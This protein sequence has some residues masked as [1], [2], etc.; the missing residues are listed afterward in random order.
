MHRQVWKSY[1]TPL[2]IH[3]LDPLEDGVQKALP[4][5]ITVNPS[6]ERL[7]DFLFTA[8][9]IWKARN[10]NRFQRKNWTYLQVLKVAEAHRLNH[11]KAQQDAATPPPQ[12]QLDPVATNSSVKCYVD[13]ATT[14]DHNQHTLQPKR[15]GLGILIVNLQGQQVNTI[16]IRAIQEGIYSVISAE[17]AALALAA[18]VLKELNLGEIAYFSDCSQLVEYIN[19]EDSPDPPDWHMLPLIQDFNLAMENIRHSVSK[20]NRELNYTA[21]SLAKLA[22]HS[23]HSQTHDYVPGCTVHSHVQQCPLLRALPYVTNAH[24]R[25]IA[26]SCC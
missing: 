6:E 1:N 16:Y 11:L 5:L 17:A 10:D 13:A 22:L 26:A 25:V 20:I 3:L 7:C 24:L 19:S 14:P 23:P 4:I 18:A 21:D 12:T 8:W 9:Y 15:A 2:P